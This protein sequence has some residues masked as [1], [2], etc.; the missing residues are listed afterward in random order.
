MGA[1]T[2]AD[3]RLANMVQHE[4]LI[5]PFSRKSLRRAGVFRIPGCRKV[6]PYSPSIRTPCTNR[7]S[8]RKRSS[9][10]SLHNMAEAFDDRVDAKMVRRLARSGCF[11]S[12]AYHPRMKE[13][14]LRARQKLSGFAFGLPGLHRYAS[15]VSFLF[16]QGLEVLGQQIPF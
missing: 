12:P 14:V 11:R 16:E 13:T 8:T 10:S 4:G 15:I 3:I 9:G 1:H 5:S 7:S 2:P 6:K